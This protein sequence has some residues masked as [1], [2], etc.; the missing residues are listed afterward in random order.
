MFDSDFDV[1][2][3]YDA[4]VVTFGECH[5]DY[6]DEVGYV[7]TEDEILFEDGTSLSIFDPFDPDTFDTWED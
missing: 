2:E 5:E 6:L 7:E 4:E 3:L 1:Q